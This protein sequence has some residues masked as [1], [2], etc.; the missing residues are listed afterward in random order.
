MSHKDYNVHTRLVAFGMIAQHKAEGT[1]IL[2]DEQNDAK[3]L[4]VA[5]R[6]DVMRLGKIAASGT[7]AEIGAATDLSALY[8]GAEP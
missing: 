1:T 2:L 3:A 6:P 5:D 8:L 4:S 7:A